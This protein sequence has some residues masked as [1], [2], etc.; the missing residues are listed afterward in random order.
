[1]SAPDFQLKLARAA[2]SDFANLLSFT[3]QTWGRAQFLAYQEKINAALAAIAENPR[4]GKP[5]HGVL[6]HQAGRHRIFYRL[7]GPVVIVL[8]I[9][10]DRMDA[11]RHLP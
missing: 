5:R 9:L 8:R 4:R 1:M 3:L 10:H 2:R 7:E 11:G 6:V